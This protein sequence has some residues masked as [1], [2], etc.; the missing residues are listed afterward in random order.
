MAGDAEH[1]GDALGE[2]RAEQAAERAGAGDL[3]E[4]LLG[5]AR[6]EALAGDQ[7]EARGEQRPGARN[8]EVDDDRGDRAARWAEQPLEEE[9]DAAGRETSAGTSVAGANRGGRPCE[10]ARPAGSS[11]TEVAISIV[12][13]A[14]KSSDVRNSASRVALPPTNWAVTAP[15]HSMV[16][17]IERCVVFIAS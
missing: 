6:I 11:T 9:Q 14:V 2:Q 10:L 17:R 15:A 8:V 16:A 3:A 13:S 5:R 1:R 4:A 7:P 12:G